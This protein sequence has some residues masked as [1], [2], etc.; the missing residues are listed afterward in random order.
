MK[1][2][3]LTKDSITLLSGIKLYRIKALKDFSNVKKGD[4][5]GYIQKESNLSH[6]GTAWVYGNAWVCG[7]A[8]VYGDARVHYRVLEKDIKNIKDNIR[9]TLNSLPINNK[10]ILYKSVNKIRKVD[11]PDLDK[12]VSC[13]SGIHVSHLTY[14]NEGDTIIACEVDIKDIITCQ[15]G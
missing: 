8:R 5:G 9:V 2:Y 1:K 6:E 13:S 3:K 14:W 4:M 11:N 7:N 12:T 10:Y 15:E